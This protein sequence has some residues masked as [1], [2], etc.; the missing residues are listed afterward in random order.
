MTRIEDWIGRS[1]EMARPGTSKL[2]I[3]AGIS[4]R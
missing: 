1:E 2:A 3:P 4:A